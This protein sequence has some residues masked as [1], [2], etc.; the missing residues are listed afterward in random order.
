MA[1]RL[2]RLL[3]V[4]AATSTLAGAPSLAQTKDSTARGG[5]TTV[6]PGAGNSAAERPPTC[7]DGSTP[8]TS[9]NEPPCGQDE[10]GPDL[11][12]GVVFLPDILLDLFGGSARDPGQPGGG[13][14]LP[15]GVADNNSPIPRDRSASTS[16]DA[17]AGVSSD[18]GNGT[19]PGTSGGGAPR[20]GAA[21]FALTVSPRAVDGAHV[22]D[23]V[24][25]TVEPGT[26]GA[27]AATFGLEVRSERQSE[28]LGATIVRFGIPD[29]RPVGLVLAQLEGD[30]RTRARAPNHIYDLQQAAGVANY[31]FERI[32]LDFGAAT[33]AGVAVAVIDTAVDAAHPALQGVV[34]AS[35]DAMPDIPVQERDHGTAIAGLIAGVGNM[36][37]MAPGAAIFH[38]RAFD[39]GKSSMDVILLAFDWAAE[40]EARI[41][42]M[43]FVGPRN[44][45]LETA[46]RAARARDMVLVAA[47]GNNGPAA[48]YSYPAA[49][50]GVIAVTATDEKDRLMPQANRGPYVY[51][52]APG[53]DVVAPVGGGTDLV[54]GTSFAAA[55]V[56]GAIANLIHTHPDRSAD[57]IEAA[58]AAA[59]RDLGAEGRDADFGHGLLN[60]EA[61]ANAR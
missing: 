48:P 11:P 14:R 16:G 56:S 58:L 21:S 22:P 30:P 55:V 4:L 39:S 44:R 3:L 33:G 8:S 37:G 25:A 29:G 52:S 54:T 41:V 28:L 20:A 35:F 59:S 38:A 2:A 50:E 36:H 31:A 5:A 17:G 46:C 61:M 45:L 1:N 18:A 26:A 42:N 24:L 49:F 60:Y 51:I 57:W 10:I 19:G 34:A 7:S 47:A 32:A 6:D 40:Q 53:V 15:Q 43:S 27:I 13:G 12:A 9:P 23:E